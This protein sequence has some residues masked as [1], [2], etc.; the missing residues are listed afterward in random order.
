MSWMTR[1]TIQTHRSHGHGIAVMRTDEHHPRS[2]ETCV[3]R[4]ARSRGHQVGSTS[5]LRVTSKCVAHLPCQLF[6]C[7]PHGGHHHSASRCKL[8]EPARQEVTAWR[9]SGD[10]NGEGPHTR[11]RPPK[12]HRSQE[13]AWGCQRTGC[14]SS[15]S[16]FSFPP[17]PPPFSSVPYAASGSWCLPRTQCAASVRSCQLANA[18]APTQLQTRR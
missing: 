11:S 8:K 14:W 12:K 2:N 15:F 1:C 16:S 5:P 13:H 17:S 7:F 4:T 18:H 6:R 10:E 9:I 3:K